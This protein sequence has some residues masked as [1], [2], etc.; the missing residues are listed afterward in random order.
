MH[1]CYVRGTTGA[2]LK[3][4]MRAHDAL[5][6]LYRMQR[7]WGYNEVVI[8]AAD[9]APHGS[10]SSSHSPWSKS[11][12]TVVVVVA[13]VVMTT[14][15]TAGTEFVVELVPQATTGVALAT[16]RPTSGGVRSPN[17]DVD[18]SLLSVKNAPIGGGEGSGD[19]PAL[20][21]GD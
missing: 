14:A 7:E 9:M 19:G 15:L 2:G 10:A 13:V 18:V 20:D 21:R 5:H 4:M 1:H 3:Q 11:S 12:S 17:A 16:R 8:S 6:P